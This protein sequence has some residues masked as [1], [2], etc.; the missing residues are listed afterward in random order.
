[1]AVFF[2]LAASCSAPAITA[3][4]LPGRNPTS[5]EFDWPKDELRTRLLGTLSIEKQLA[6]PIFG[7]VAAPGEEAEGPGIFQVSDRSNS[8][9]GRELLEMPGNNDDFYLQAFHTAF[10][11]SPVYSARG[12]V[13]PFLA[14]FHVHFSVL[15]QGRT[16][17]TVTAHR[18]EVLNGTRF[19]F[20]HNGL[21][22]YA[23][24]MPVEPTTIEEY[25]VLRY[26]GESLGI[27]DM[28][29]VILPKT[30]S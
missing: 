30:P 23:R 15:T 10:W 25:T 28:P 13:L 21:G 6:K 2:A 11:S 29:P 27:R 20:G 3:V 17:I 4:A 7:A 1:M 26:F 9:M 5:Y 22:R 18:T 24:Y 16:K 19:D 14:E 8:V 12:K